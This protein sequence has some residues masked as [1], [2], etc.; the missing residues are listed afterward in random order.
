[1]A[2]ELKGIRYLSEKYAD[3]KLSTL[4]NRVNEESLKEAHRKQKAEKASG[5]D[6]VTKAEFEKNLDEN[7]ANIIHSMK[8]LEYKPLA[9]RRVE[10]PKPGG[11]KRPLGIPAYGDRLVQSAMANILTE[12]YEPKF[13]D[14]SYGFRPGRTAHQVVRYIDQ[15]IAWKQVNYVLEADIKGF[16]DNLDQRQLME[17]LERDISDR[18]FLRYIGRF[19]KAGVM[20]GTEIQP[21]DKGTPQG[22][23]LSPILA[24]VY[25]HYVLDT[26]VEETVKGCM[27]GEMYYVRYADDFLFMFQYE[28]DAVR[29][30][31][32]LGKR[33]GKYGLEL[34][35]DKTRILPIGRRTGTKEKFDFLGFTFYNTKSRRGKYML[36]VK[37][38]EKKLK[39]K[40]QT[41]K[42]WL[43]ARLLRP[44]DE[45]LYSLGRKLAGHNNYY[46]V[47]GNYNALQAFWA[48]AWRQ[49]F[50]MLNRRSQRKSISYPTFDRLW[51]MYVKSPRITVQIW[52]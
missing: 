28:S 48:Y 30:R 39:A 51:D 44:V 49:T 11:K 43:R 23:Q 46:G 17:F 13:L 9:V 27:R 36:G 34:A 41:L 33:L 42:A 2:S 29:V 6:G 24:N 25:L 21:S 37:T 7:V 1:M 38:S 52:S 5:V 22:G 35:E 14:C 12:V 45:T 16:F 8:T 31:N 40:R 19:L 3:S 50:K 26:W 10:I 18:N 15:T 4:M 20:V 32:V 47:N